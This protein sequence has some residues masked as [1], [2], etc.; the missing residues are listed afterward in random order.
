[1]RQTIKDA[2][3]KGHPTTLGLALAWAP[4][5][6]LWLGDLLAAEAHA[7]R[8]IAHAEAHSLTPYL[9]VGQS[10]KGAV[11]IRR[12]DARAGVA[13]LESGL[14]QQHALRYEMHTEFKLFLAEGLLATGRSFEALA[15]IEETIGLIETKGD[16][17]HLPEALRIKGCVLL[18]LPHR[19]GDARAC[20]K[21]SLDWSRRQGA[22]SW[23]LRTARDLAGAPSCR[24]AGL[25]ARS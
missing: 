17:L 15:L 2:E 22:R 1:V 24:T 23:E 25:Q 6:F 10:Y 13:D 5:L 16:L 3:R 8:L 21:R 9:A 12:G 4:G 14:R 18:S 7:D 11:A 20:L 19:R